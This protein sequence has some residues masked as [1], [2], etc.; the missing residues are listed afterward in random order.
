MIAICVGHSRP[1]DMGAVSIGGVSE[2]VFNQRLA[3]SI[4]ADLIERGRPATVI[5]S[6]QG[7]N[8]SAAMR[9]LAAEH[10]RI[11]ATVTVELHFNSSDTAQASGHEWLFWVASTQGRFLAKALDSRMSAAFPELP[12]RGIKSI[13]QGDRGA[14]FL[15]LTPCPAIICEPFFGSN[16]RDWDLANNQQDKLAGVIAQG[17]DD[18]MVGGSL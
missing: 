11:G 5:S 18:F 4:A 3:R 17:L 6:Y 10:R 12:R 14:E 7:S 2:H 1:G 13:H 8:Y 9:W 16:D 15:R